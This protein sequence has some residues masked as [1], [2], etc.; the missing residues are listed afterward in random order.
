MAYK[1]QQRVTYFCDCTAQRKES[2]ITAKNI[3][4]YR[5]KIARKPNSALGFSTRSV[6]RR[7]REM[8]NPLYLALTIPEC[9]TL[10]LSPVQHRHWSVSREYHE[11]GWEV[12]IWPEETVFSASRHSSTGTGTPP[13]GCQT[14]VLRG[15]QGWADKSLKKLVWTQC[16]FCSEQ[17]AALAD[18]P[19]LIWTV[20]SFYGKKQLQIIIHI[21][22]QHIVT[23]EVINNLA[24]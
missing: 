8:I 7:S 12:L 14:S 13:R 19:R 15:L 24:S 5:I 6:G 9:C 11:H 20:L 22:F 18:F 2:K 21:F 4:S 16:W 1:P 23:A 17:E 3:K 10:V